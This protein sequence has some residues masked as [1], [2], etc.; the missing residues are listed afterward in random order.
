MISKMKPARS[1]AEG[2]RAQQHAVGI[3]DD[4]TSWKKRIEKQLKGKSVG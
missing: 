3:V 4:G 2:W 1:G